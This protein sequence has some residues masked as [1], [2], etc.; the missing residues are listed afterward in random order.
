MYVCISVCVCMCVC[1]RFMILQVQFVST[2]L[3]PVERLWLDLELPI[4]DLQEVSDFI[5]IR[6][7]IL[8]GSNRE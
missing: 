5:V 1:M 4:F 2:R 8:K 6:Y 3:Y 7:V